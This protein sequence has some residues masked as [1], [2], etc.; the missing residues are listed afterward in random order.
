MWLKSIGILCSEMPKACSLLTTLVIF[1]I[2]VQDVLQDSTP[3][4]ARN[5]DALDLFCG[6]AAIHRAA[7]DSGLAST[8][9]DKFRVPGI[10]D[11]GKA[12]LTEDLSSKSGFMR[13]LE[14]VKQLR[15]G[16]LLVMGP[17]CSSFV[18]LNAK[19]C[20]RN[21]Q[22]N[23]QGDLKY[24]PVQLGNLLATAAAFL[25]TVACMRGVEVVFENPPSSTIWKF[26]IVKQVLDSFVQRSTCTPRCAWSTEPWGKRMLKR[27]KFACT[28]TWISDIRCKCRCPGRRH[29]R[30]TGRVWRNGKFRFTGKGLALKKSAAYPDALGKAIVNAWRKSTTSC[31]TVC[32][33]H[34]SSPAWLEICPGAGNSLTYK[35]PAGTKK[36]RKPLPASDSLPAWLQPSPACT[37]VS[38]SQPDWLQPKAIVARKLTSSTTGSASGAPS[39]L[40]P[41]PSSCS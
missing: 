37:S 12:G 34:A 39:W 40:N 22:N 2:S 3:D 7:V 24:P 5:K 10:T 1:G 9:F 13:A 30:L 16:G 11:S 17:P 6:A 38:S 25:M 31:P 23:Y 14:L 28:G 20:Q 26:P 32:S 41:A 8:A 21:A 4:V 18:V 35:R 33:V 36:M 15:R 19:N 27:F 29:L